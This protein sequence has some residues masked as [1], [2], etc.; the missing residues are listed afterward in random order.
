MYVYVSHTDDERSSLLKLQNSLDFIDS[1]RY[2]IPLGKKFYT[3]WSYRNIDWKKSNTGRR[4][5][6][7]WVSQ[8]LKDNL[9]TM[10]LLSEARDWMLPS[11]HVP[12]FLTLSN[13]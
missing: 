2:F 9:Y 10:N 4:L 7:I 13:L 11:D 3:W 1:S 8:N 6:H 12:Y 5:D